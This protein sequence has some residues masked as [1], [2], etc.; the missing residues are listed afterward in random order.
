MRFIYFYLSFD[1]TLTRAG[2]KQVGWKEDK[3]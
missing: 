1:S 3:P 2:M